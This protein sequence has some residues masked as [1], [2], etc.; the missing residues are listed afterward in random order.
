MMPIAEM[1]ALE[2]I[3]AF[4]RNQPKS[5]I[6]GVDEVGRGSLFGPVFAGVVMLPLEDL[7]DLVKLGVKDSKKLTSRG[8]E[9]MFQALLSYGCTYRLGYAT[10]QEID[11]LNILQASLLAM[12]RAVQKLKPEPLCCLVDGQFPI[13]GLMLPQYTLI[14]G[15][16]RSPLIAAASIIAKCTRDAL[17]TRF[18]Q[19]YPQYGLSAHQGYGTLIHR[20]ALKRYGPTP[21]HRLSFAPLSRN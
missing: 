2:G 7:S 11:R 21:Q 17:I 15:D 8:R 6:A 14:K 10:A 19:K 9:K 3:P 20:Q 16:A 1:S 18:A 13:P 12:Y 5:L 4:L